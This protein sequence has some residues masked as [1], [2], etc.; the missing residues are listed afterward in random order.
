[1]ILKL[2]LLGKTPLSFI[3]IFSKFHLKAK[4][5]TQRF[6]G[7]LYFQAAT[8]YVPFYDIACKVVLNYES[9]YPNAGYLYDARDYRVFAAYKC[10]S[11]NPI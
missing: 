7:K 1:M 10:N 8:F 5:D 6:R 3:Q 11:G 9:R 4:V 2:S